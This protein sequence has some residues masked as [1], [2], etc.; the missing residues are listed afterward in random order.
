MIVEGDD[1]HGDG[2]NI[3]DRLQA[4]A[5]ARRRRHLRHRLRP[6]EGQAAGRLRLAG[7]AEGQEHRRAG[8]GLPRRCMDPAAPARRSARESATW[9][10]LARLPAAG[11]GVS[12][13]GVA[14]GGVVAAVAAGSASI[15][16]CRRRC[17]A[18][19]RPSLVVLPFD[20]L[21][22]DK[23]QGYL[24]DG[25]TED[26]TTELARI[27]GLFVIS[28]NAAFTYKGQGDAAGRDRR[29]ARRPLPAR[30]LSAAPATT[31]ASTPS[32]STRDRRPSLGGALRRRLGDVFTL[33]DE[34]V[35]KVAAALE[36]QL[37]SSRSAGGP[38]LG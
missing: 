9:R 36:L 30:R 21:S 6:G 15:D 14:A 5:R 11:R 35:E 17:T 38:D 34:V 13:P 23:E 3:A 22:D 4:L 25:I 24:A 7:R 37:V 28:R 26:L 18:D 20:N 27:P 31:S 33:Q 1:I 32:S 12:R 10:I 29:G 16:L 19:A 8:A 2:V